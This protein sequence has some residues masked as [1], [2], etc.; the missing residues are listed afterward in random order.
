MCEQICV[1]RLNCRKLGGDSGEALARR[2]NFRTEVVG[3]F[4]G[5][6]GQLEPVGGNAERVGERTGGN[7]A[8]RAGVVK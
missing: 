5:E 8:C 3:Q 2:Q 6:C 1:P 4:L 7:G